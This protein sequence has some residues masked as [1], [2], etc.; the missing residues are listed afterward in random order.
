MECRLGRKLDE[1]L[2]SG[3]TNLIRTSTIS[4]AITDYAREKGVELIGHH[5]TAAATQL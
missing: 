1:T 2:D 3:D 5:E 4:K